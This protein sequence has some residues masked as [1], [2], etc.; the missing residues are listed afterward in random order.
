MDVDNGREGKK[1]G[2]RRTEQKEKKLKKEKGLHWF[3][4]NLKKWA[5]NLVEWFMGT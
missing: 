4:L 2:V 5:N 1:E 3:K